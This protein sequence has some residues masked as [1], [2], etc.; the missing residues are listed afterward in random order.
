MYRIGKEEKDAVARVIDSKELFKVNG[1]NL[2][3]TV[4]C[5]KEMREL[6]NTRNAIL[7]TSGKAALISALVAMG[8]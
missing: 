5:E 8:V 2:Q 6:F 7:M 1:G 4:N 3:E